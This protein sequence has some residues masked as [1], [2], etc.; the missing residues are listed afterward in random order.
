MVEL[1]QRLKE[2]NVP[3]R[4]NVSVPNPS[5]KN[6]GI[7]DQVGVETGNFKPLHDRKTQ[8]VISSDWHLAQRFWTKFLL[9]NTMNIGE[10]AS[11]GELHTKF[12]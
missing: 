10:K 1:R 2:L 12:A 5:D 11:A 9:L 3:S 6:T 7:V 4:K 8:N